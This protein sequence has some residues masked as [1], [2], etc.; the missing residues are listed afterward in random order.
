MAGKLRGSMH[1]I[2][3]GNSPPWRHR[4]RSCRKDGLPGL[5]QWRHLK[6]SCRN[7]GGVDA[8]SCRGVAVGRWGKTH[9]GASI[10]GLPGSLEKEP[11]KSSST[12]DS[13]ARLLHGSDDLRSA[14][15]PSL[16]PFVGFGR[17]V[18]P[19]AS[20][21]RLVETVGLGLFPGSNLAVPSGP[22]VLFVIQYI[23]HTY[24]QTSKALLLL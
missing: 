17:V 18:V 14:I 22:S 19:E 3:T 9:P 16:P 5:T 6:Q 13:Q 11:Q 23:V 15:S 2:G 21:T 7:P 24:A 1:H 12:S 4:M 10:R 20:W 8:W